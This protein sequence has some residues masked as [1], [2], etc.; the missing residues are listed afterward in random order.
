MPAVTQRTSTVRVKRFTVLG[1]SSIKRSPATVSVVRSTGSFPL[2][3][4]SMALFNRLCCYSTCLPGLST[5]PFLQAGVSTGSSSSAPSSKIPLT[6]SL[7]SEAT[8]GAPKASRQAIRRKGSGKY[9]TS[10]PPYGCL[11]SSVC[12]RSLVHNIWRK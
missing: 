7:W 8:L 5:G 4:C 11:Y 2:V 12:R 1:L 10:D 6:L 9:C 3:K